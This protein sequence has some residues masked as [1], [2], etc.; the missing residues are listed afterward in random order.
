MSG[1]ERLHGTPCARDEA[2]GPGLRLTSRALPILVAMA[3][4]MVSGASLSA[5]EHGVAAFECVP[6]GMGFSGKKEW[7]RH[8]MEAHGARGCTACGVLFTNGSEEKAAHEILH[9]GATHCAACGRDFRT[10]REAMDHLVPVHHLPAC[11]LHHVVFAN[12]EEAKLHAARC[13]TFRA[14]FEK[15]KKSPRVR[16]P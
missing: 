12:D 4:M 10:N 14:Q 6:C 1:C 11:Q 16:K 15:W 7:S 9:H 5:E 2:L 8:E 3:L 13:P